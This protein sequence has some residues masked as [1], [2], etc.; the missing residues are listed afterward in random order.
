MTKETGPPVRSTDG[1]DK[2]F[3]PLP[4]QAVEAPTIDPLMLQIVSGIE[5]DLT[6]IKKR[7][8]SLDLLQTQL[9]VIE[10]QLDSVTV[11]VS[12]S[13]T[14]TLDPAA[15]EE[16]RKQAEDMANKFEEEEQGKM[17]SILNQRAAAGIPN[18]GDAVTD[19]DLEAAANEW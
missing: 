9:S 1:D 8:S 5:R 4:G 13:F 10:R 3:Y 11:L 19:A 15:K 6:D 7:L 12:R 18:D 2:R 14:A 17:Q 16:A